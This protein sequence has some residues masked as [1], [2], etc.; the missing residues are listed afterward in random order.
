MYPRQAYHEI[1]NR[2]ITGLFGASIGGVDTAIC[3][4]AVAQ[5]CLIWAEKV[6]G[7]TGSESQ[8]SNPKHKQA[9]EKSSLLMGTQIPYVSEIPSPGN[10]HPFSN[11]CCSPLG[12]G[13]E[14]G[15]VLRM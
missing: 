4:V 3:N 6:Q 13:L 11:G 9:G 7:G 15:L 10:S 8:R 1:I 5:Y 2:I 14:L 12:L